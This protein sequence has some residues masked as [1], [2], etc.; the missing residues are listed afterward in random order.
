MIEIRIFMHKISQAYIVLVYGKL[1]ITE[2]FE[3]SSYCVDNYCKTLIFRVTLF[4]RAHDF[5]FI[6]E[7]LFSRLFISCTIIL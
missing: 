3:Y 5:G 6:H 7:T 4:S 2:L 1:F